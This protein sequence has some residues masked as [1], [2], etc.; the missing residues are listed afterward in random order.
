[1]IRING[2]AIAVNGM[3]NEIAVGVIVALAAGYMIR[4]LF[5]RGGCGPCE[6]AQCRATASESLVQLE[7]P[8]ASGPAQSSEMTASPKP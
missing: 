2:G 4:H 6:G 5:L 7:P 8:A 3:W 1:M